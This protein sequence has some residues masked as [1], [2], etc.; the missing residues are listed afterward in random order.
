MSSIMGTAGNRP[1]GGTQL[2]PTFHGYIGSTMDALILF[3]ACLTGVLTHVPRRPH[4]RERAS[5]IV[6][7]NVFIYEENSSGIKRWTDGVPWSPSRILG[8]FLL[9]RELDKPFQPGEKKRALKRSKAESAGVSKPTHTSRAN[10][11]S[12]FSSNGMATGAN[13]M[14]FENSPNNRNETERALVGSL[15]DSYQFREDGLVKKTI[16]VTHNGIQHHMVSYYKIEDVI[17]HKLPTP[18]EANELHNITPRPALIS[19]GNF[20]APVDDH[21]IVMA[22]PHLR[23]YMN[24]PQQYSEYGMNNTA[25]RSMSMPSM[26]NYGPWAGGQY[27]QY[28]MGNPLPP[29]SYPSSTASTYSYG[30]AQANAAAY[31][32]TPRSSLSSSLPFPS[33]SPVSTRRS[34]Y[35]QAMNNSNHVDYPRYSNADRTGMGSAD[36]QPAN[37]GS[38]I[39]YSRYSNADRIGMATTDRFSM[40]TNQYLSNGGELVNHGPSSQEQPYS[41]GNIFESSASALQA[42]GTAATIAN[43]ATP[44]PSQQHSSFT[45]SSPNQSDE[46][47]SG[48]DSGHHSAGFNG[49]FDN[50]DGNTVP[51]AA[52]AFGAP[53]PDHSAQNFASSDQDPTNPSLHLGLENSASVPNAM[54][55]TDWSA[56]FATDNLNQWVMRKK[57]H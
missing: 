53:L 46:M 50:Y 52:T 1:L 40:S 32:T 31:T 3:E 18:G 49:H 36:N 34:S 47:Y 15:V 43:A 2:R 7:G 16:S 38:H 19:S 10:S 57:E 24:A 13:S 30:Q 54:P 4:D 56:G 20:R 21:E 8:N 28:G 27:V 55:G 37:N 6:S 51:Q 35:N 42:N 29:M 26:H 44:S 12:G 23:G 11:I 39:D 48:G 14:S 33:P 5:L 25:A 22:D 17:H 9:Y 45:H 41:N